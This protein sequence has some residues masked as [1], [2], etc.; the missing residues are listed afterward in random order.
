MEQYKYLLDYIKAVRDKKA[1][2]RDQTG[3]DIR[4]LHLLV[5]MLA[6]SQLLITILNSL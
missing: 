6:V 2:L 5:V 1:I 3:R 4:T